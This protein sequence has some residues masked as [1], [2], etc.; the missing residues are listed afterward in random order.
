M[1]PKPNWKVRVPMPKITK[2][3]YLEVTVEQFLSACSYLELQEINM[4]LDAHLRRAE[5]K[6]PDRVEHL[7]DTGTIFNPIQSDENT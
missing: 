3:F 6:Q 4:R 5:N 7:S 1:R 2:Q